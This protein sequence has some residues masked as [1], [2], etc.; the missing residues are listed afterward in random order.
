MDK[1]SIEA[2]ISH[3]LSVLLAAMAFL[4]FMVSLTQFSNEDWKTRDA[5]TSVGFVLAFC[6]STLLSLGT[7]VDN[8]KKQTML[9]KEYIENNKII[10]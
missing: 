1:K 6:S 10:Q 2:K 4:I 3:A 5:F 8:S 9:I 7:M